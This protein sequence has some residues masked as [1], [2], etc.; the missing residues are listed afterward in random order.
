MLAAEVLRTMNERKKTQMFVLDDGRPVGMIHMHDLLKAGPGVK[1]VI[2]IPA[3]YASR[4][5]PGKPLHKIDGVSMLART[6]RRGAAGREGD[7]RA[8]ADRNRRP[9]HRRPCQGDR[10]RE[11]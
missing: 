6:A 7:R 11:P 9:A 10:R 4:R 1:T 5:F 8:R 3:R 2:V